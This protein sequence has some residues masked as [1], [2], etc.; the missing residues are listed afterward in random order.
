MDNIKFRQNY[1][2][3]WNVYI[4]LLEERLLATNLAN[5][6]ILSKQKIEH[7]AN[8]VVALDEIVCSPSAKHGNDHLSGKRMY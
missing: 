2:T 4:K 3:R 5:T 1:R 6:R 7:F 8:K